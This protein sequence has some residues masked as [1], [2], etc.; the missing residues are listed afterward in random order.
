MSGRPASTDPTQTTITTTGTDAGSRKNPR[1][2][3]VTAAVA[4]QEPASS[5][6]AAARRSGSRRATWYPNA[7]RATAPADQSAGLSDV[8]AFTTT[9]VSP[10]AAA[11]SHL[12]GFT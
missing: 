12:I 1:A 11:T 5:T 3:P 4:A 6:P 9:K 7:A 8:S 2:S 10:G